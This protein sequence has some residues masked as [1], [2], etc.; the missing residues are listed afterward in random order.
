[1]F[2][3]AYLLTSTKG[4]AIALTF[5]LFA[6]I[7]HHFCQI[8]TL[9]ILPLFVSYTGLLLNGSGG[10]LFR[11]FSDTRMLQH[12]DVFLLA[13]LIIEQHSNQLCQEILKAVET[14]TEFLP[15]SKARGFP[16]VFW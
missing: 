14:A 4:I 2:I 11:D 10:S 5:K 9:H 16:L 12:V 3:C 7:I 8:G 13:N 1:M 15:M 6:F